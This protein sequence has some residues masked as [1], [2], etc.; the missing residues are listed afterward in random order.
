[1]CGYE[2]KD[3]QLRLRE[4]WVNH[5]PGE[6][7]I[8]RRK[9]PPDLNGAAAVRDEKS[10]FGEWHFR[11]VGLPL[12]YT[13]GLV[14]GREFIHELYVHMGFHPA[15][16]YLQVHELVFERGRL[17]QANDASP[18]MAELRARMQDGL[19]PEPQATREQITGWIADCFSR[20]YNRN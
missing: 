16:K 5:Q 18:R 10:F 9:Q 19:K 1:M 13:G 15:W 3:G 8:T 11:D 20:D 12:A 2:V 6:A 14:I 17:I 4:L 7:P